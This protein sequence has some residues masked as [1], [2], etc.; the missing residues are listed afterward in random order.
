MK[1]RVDR[2]EERSAAFLVDEVEPAFANALRR[3]LIADL[4]DAYCESLRRMVDDDLDALFL[5][6]FKLPG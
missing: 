4:G 2:M 6:V 3:S 5:C 1:V